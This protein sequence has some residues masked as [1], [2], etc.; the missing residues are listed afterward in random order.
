MLHY[1][2]IIVIEIMKNVPYYIHN[3][4]INCHWRFWRTVNVDRLN[5][6]LKE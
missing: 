1:W 4:G 3:Q 6:C 2:T 5:S